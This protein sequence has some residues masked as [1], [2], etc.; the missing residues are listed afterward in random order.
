MLE[1]EDQ[2]E[3]FCGYLLCKSGA[4]TDGGNEDQDCPDDAPSTDCTWGQTHQP[5]SGLGLDF[6]V[7]QVFLS[8]YFR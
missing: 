6:R 5:I 7:L 1:V 4:F 3:I 2:F 8:L